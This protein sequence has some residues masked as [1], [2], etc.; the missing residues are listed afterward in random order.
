MPTQ[1]RFSLRFPARDLV[2]VAIF[3]SV[4]IVATYAIGMVGLISPL[5]WLL[6]VPASIIVNGIPFMLFLTRVKHAGTVALFG[7]IVGLF[8]LLT[9]NTL[10]ST[11]AIV[12]LGMAAEL[13]LLAAH[14]R[15]RWAAIWAYTVF[16]LGFFSPFL[17]LLYDRE[18]YFATAGWTRM[19]D[20]YVRASDEMHS[21][22]V[23]GLLALGILIAGFLGGLLG[24]AVLGKHFVRAGLA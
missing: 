4:F 13:I 12:L 19:G 2:N 3:A 22:P 20:D 6:V 16:S 9:G 23:L 8:Y 21:A 24:S 7:V 18:G 1:P 5:T 17:P 15:S 14:Y 11:M 10:V